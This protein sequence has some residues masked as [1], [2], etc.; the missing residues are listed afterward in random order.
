MKP[1]HTDSTNQ[2]KGPGKKMA[3]YEPLIQEADPHITKL[4]LG[5]GMSEK[6]VQKTLIYYRPL[7][8]CQ[9]G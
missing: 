4:A 8:A 9:L 1:T 5:A 6:M 7:E 2:V 3:G